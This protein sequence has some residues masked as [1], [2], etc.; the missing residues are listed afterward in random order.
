MIYT[1]NPKLQ[2]LSYAKKIEKAVNNVFKSNSYILGEY[3]KKFEIEFAKYINTKYAIG[4]G[5][6]T[7]AIELVL[8]AL[9]IGYGDEVIT[10][11]HTALASVAAIQCAGAIPI[12]CDIEKESFTIDS[13]KLSKLISKKTKAVLAVHLYGTSCNLKEIKKICKINRIHLIEDVSQ[14]HGA[15]YM[16]KKLGSIGIAGCFSCYPTKNLGAIGD[17]GVITT[18]NKS[19]AKKLY[20]MRQYGWEKSNISNYFGRNSRLDEIQAA[21]L[22]EKLKVLDKNNQLRNKIALYYQNNLTEKVVKPREQDYSDHVYHLYVIKTNYAKKLQKYLL[23][24]NISCGIHYPLPVHLQP[25]YKEK[26]KIKHKL[27]NT[28]K[29]VNNIISIPIYPELKMNEYK[30]ICMKINNFFDNVSKKN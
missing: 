13:I 19:L 26:I 20:A 7:D 10:V 16:N 25:A 5:N 12:L 15:H 18:N 27:E 14:A 28:E 9:N 24:F 4:V 8:R 30:F 23:K 29:L 21:I 11:S 3:V 17:A 1:S 6:G 2:Y 22:I